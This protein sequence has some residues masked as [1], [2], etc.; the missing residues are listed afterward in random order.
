MSVCLGLK[1]FIS[2]SELLGQRFR[3]GLKIIIIAKI[4][5]LPVIISGHCIY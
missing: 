3:L 4:H 2:L 5:F 1:C